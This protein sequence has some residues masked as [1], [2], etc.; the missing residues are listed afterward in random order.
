MKAKLIGPLSGLVFVVLAT[1]ALL[2]GGKTPSVTDPADK[3]VAFYADK[4]DEQQAAAGLLALACVALLFFLGTLYKTLRASAGDDGGLSTVVV[5][6]G[7]MIA[8]GVTVFAGL[9][10]T[11]GD[12]ADNLPAAATLALNALNSDLF[13]SLAVG[14]AVFNIGLALAILRHGGLPRPLGM[15]ALV[16]GVA[17]ATPAGYI[18]SLATGLVIAWSSISLTMQA[19]SAERA[20]ISP[21]Q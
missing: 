7:L 11:L 5:L 20:A 18:A 21:G 4:A 12:A 14:T 10:F 6:G 1:I 2:I 13:I 8:V 17:C 16:V 19:M 9:G 3:V 15:L